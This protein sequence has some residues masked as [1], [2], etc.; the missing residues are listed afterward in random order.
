MLWSFLKCVLPLDPPSPLTVA[1]F[2]DHLRNQNTLAVN[3]SLNLE[4]RRSF[5]VYT[6]G[7]SSSAGNTLDDA[8]NIPAYKGDRIYRDRVTP[9]APDFYKLRLFDKSDVTSVFRNRSDSAINVTAL[10]AEGNP[11]LLANG[12]S[13]AF[14]IRPNSSESVDL[15][16]IPAGTYY[17]QVSTKG[18]KSAYRLKIAIERSCGCT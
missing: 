5:R 4:N 18:D 13:A 3:A 12:D 14:K 9:K 8:V 10:D 7:R 15:I 16:K 17:L 2:K 6:S 1:M 11:A